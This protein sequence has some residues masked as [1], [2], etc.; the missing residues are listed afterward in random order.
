MKNGTILPT[1]LFIFVLSIVVF[2]FTRCGKAVEEEII[3]ETAIC[4]EV[5][6]HVKDRGNDVYEIP[7]KNWSDH[8]LLF[9]TCNNLRNT[10]DITPLK[11]GPGVKFY[12]EP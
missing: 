1:L 10:R 6:M 12:A 8:Y 5:R 11:P 4:K 3:Q 7:G 2:L 9:L